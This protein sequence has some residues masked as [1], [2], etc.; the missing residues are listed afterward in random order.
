L[1]EPPPV[2]VR[3]NSRK[4]AEPF[5]EI[6]NTEPI[7][8]CERGL[9]LPGRPSFILDPLWH[10]G[11]YYVQEAS[12]MLLNTAL[13]QFAGTPRRVL[14][15]CAA[16]GGKTT[17]LADFL[18][19]DALLIANETIRSRVPMLQENVTRWGWPNVAVT[20][21]DPENFAP[22]AG[23]FDVVVIDAPCSGEGMFR[24]DPKAIAEWSAENAAM[25]AAR[26]KRILTAALPLIRPGGLLLYSTCTFNPDENDGAAAFVL[27]QGGFE[28]LTLQMPA[29]WGMTATE[30]GVSCYPHQ[31]RGEGFYLTVLR[32]DG[33]NVAEIM[34]PAPANET[35]FDAAEWLTEPERFTFTTNKNAEIIALPK[36]I[37]ADVEQVHFVLPRLRS[38]LRLGGFKGRDFVPA[39]EL[40][41]SAA[42]ADTIPRLPLSRLEAVRYLRKE[43]PDV[44]ADTPHG[45]TLA[46]YENLPL[47]WAKV[48]PGRM[49]NYLP[50][51][52][53]IRQAERER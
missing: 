50:T 25:C 11:A 43:T 7:P 28:V 47:G 34:R 24:K 51:E 38:G 37:V 46:T 5:A 48:M 33:D 41:L 53:R 20:N 18:A 15:L 8:W 49:N 52:W 13:R 19:D 32:R 17:L 30:Y 29:A 42:V 3:R 44:P 39:H 9:Y 16:P 2:S 27:A 40:A 4:T 22:L 12:S 36:A 45:W 1:E 31:C 35:P 26:Q 6:A 21:E 23:F 10:A 14:D